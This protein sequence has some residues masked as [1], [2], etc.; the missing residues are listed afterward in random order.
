MRSSDCLTS[1]RLDGGHASE[2][3]D[4]VADLVR[5]RQG[6]LTILAKELVVDL[7]QLPPNDVAELGILDQPRVLPAEDLVQLL[8]EIDPVLRHASLP[9]L[10]VMALLR[11]FFDSN[12]PYERITLEPQSNTAQVISSSITPGDGKADG[13]P[14]YVVLEHRWNGVHWDF[15]LEIETTLRTWAVEVPIRAGIDVPARSLADHRIAYLD[16]E[17]P[18]SGNRGSVRQFDR[19]T[20]ERV[21]WEPTRVV[22]LLEGLQLA[23][24]VE[25]RRNETGREPE[26]PERWTLRLRGNVA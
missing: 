19:G 23:G 1:A 22:V 10:R 24:V 13:M 20:Y 3:H 9:G 2:G 4:L 21:V 12:R 5:V 6:L 11:W 18:V 8:D 7:P 17:G 25:L 15:M 14:R 16:Y 26:S